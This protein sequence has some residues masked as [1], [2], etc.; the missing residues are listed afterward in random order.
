M[1]KITYLIT[2]ALVALMLVMPCYADEVVTLPEETTITEAQETATEAQ[3]QQPEQTP[4]QE[5]E[6]P[7]E[8]AYTPL[9]IDSAIDS[10]KDKITDR[11]TW[12]MIGTGIL[13]ALTIVATV[14]AKFGSIVQLFGKDKDG[15]TVHESIDAVK[16]KVKDALDPI[17]KEITAELEECKKKLQTSE[18]NN[19]KLYAM[20][21]LFMTNCNIGDSAKKEILG[22]ATEIKK[23]EGTLT[24]IVEQAQEAIDEAIAEQEQNARPT[25]TLDQLLEED[26]MELG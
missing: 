17:M 24:E 23:Y 9:D 8:D 15:K 3:E 11:A 4:N 16:D 10:I 5:A 26:Y 2:I 14:A 22:I 21:T 19:Q 20:L 25:P 13:T 1:K 7:T 18:D 12:T 6:K